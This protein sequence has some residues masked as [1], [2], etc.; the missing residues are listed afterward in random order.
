MR[1]GLRMSTI[2]RNADACEAAKTTR[3]ACHCGGQFHGLKHSGAWRKRIFVDARRA[4]E[5]KFATTKK[6]KK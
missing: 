2:D 5:A 6:K 1:G 4:F 3:C